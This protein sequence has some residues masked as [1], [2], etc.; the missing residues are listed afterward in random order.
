[1]MTRRTILLPLLL[2]VFFALAGASVA[3][4]QGGEH[5]AGLVVRF[6]D[7]SVQTSC[8]SFGEPSISGEQLLN[9]SGLAVVMDYNA[10][11]GGA[12]CSISGYGCPVTDCFC[13]CQ[14]VLCE[15]WA[16]YHGSAGGWQYAPT[17]TS[18]YQVTDGALEGWSWGNGAFW[19]LRYRAAGHDIR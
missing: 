4:A 19:Y 10:G 2:T 11:L 16:Y 18:S 8:V 7:G 13:R 14:G 1:M 9:R 15:Y 17:G 5:R 6:A 3:H 12:V